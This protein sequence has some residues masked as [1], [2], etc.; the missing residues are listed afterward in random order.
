MLDDGKIIDNVRSETKSVDQ[1]GKD[2]VDG[3]NHLFHLLLLLYLL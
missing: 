3:K 1:F 2:N